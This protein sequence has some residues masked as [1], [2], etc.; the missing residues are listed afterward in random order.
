MPKH[1]NPQKPKKPKEKSKAEIL[2][3]PDELT[4]GRRL[5]STAQMMRIF[6]S[7]RWT[8]WN[9]EQNDPQFPAAIFIGGGLKRWIPEEV[10]EYIASSPRRQYIATNDS[11][12][13]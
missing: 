10:H 7:S 2:R 8:I 11:V 6:G 9:L 3:E 1:Q 4:E 13:R 5:Y 12:A